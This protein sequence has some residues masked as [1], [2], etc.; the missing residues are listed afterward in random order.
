MPVKMIRV[1]MLINVELL[2]FSCTS[3]WAGLQQGLSVQVPSVTRTFD[4]YLPEKKNDHTKPLVVL[5][6]GHSGDSDVMTG[7]NKR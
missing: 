2:W 5:F 6:H 3:V 1:L 4:L 7:E